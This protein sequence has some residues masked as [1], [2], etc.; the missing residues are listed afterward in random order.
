MGG[1]SC[2]S[3]GLSL[4]LDLDDV[5][6]FRDIGYRHSTIQHCPHNAMGNEEFSYLASDSKFKRKNAAYDEGR[7]FGCG[8]RCR[9]PKKKREIEDS[10][11]FC[12]NIWVNLLNQQRGHE[13]HVEALNGNEMEEHIREDYLRQFGN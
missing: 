5:H 11:G 13:R 10:M 12:V 2:H 3:I 4:T 9:C 8:C 1:R 6:Y 7:E